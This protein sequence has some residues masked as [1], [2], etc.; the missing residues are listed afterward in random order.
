MNISV[1]QG[2]LTMV[3]SGQALVSNNDTTTLIIDGSYHININFIEDGDDKTQGL[4]INPISNGVDVDL[5]NFNNP[6]GTATTNPIAIAKQN[7]QTIYLALGAT[8]IGTT[9]ILTYCIY[10]GK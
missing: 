9:R 7:N 4:S 10:I 6:L 2:E 8:S 1:K 5:K 3:H